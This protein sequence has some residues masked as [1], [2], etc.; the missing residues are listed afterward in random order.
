MNGVKLVWLIMPILLAVSPRLDAQVDSLFADDQGLFLAEF[1][2]YV[3]QQNKELEPQV[4][5]F[6]DV[7]EG[8]M[9]EFSREMVMQTANKM[10]GQ[11][12]PAVPLYGYYIEAV[13]AYFNG[14]RGNEHFFSWDEVVKQ[15]VD[16]IQR[17]NLND[18]LGFLGFSKIFFST[19]R[20]RI[21]DLGTNW[22][23][24]DTAWTFR[25]V[26]DMPGLVFPETD[27]VAI[28]KQDSIRI[29]ATSGVFFPLQL[30]WK[31][32]GGIVGWN[33][34]EGM[35]DVYCEF[36]EYEID[37]SKGFYQAKNAQLHYPLYFSDKLIPGTFEDKLVVANAATESS[38]PR[39]ESNEK[40]LNIDNFGKG[41]SFTGGFRM[42]GTTI[43]GTG[44][45]ENRAR[46]LLL[47]EKNEEV[48]LRAEAEL[49]TIRQEELIFGEDVSASLY[50]EKSDS[51][52]HPSIIM[53]YEIPKELLQLTRGKDGNDRYP[54]S[55]TYH[56]INIEAEKIMAYLEKDSL[57]IGASR[58]QRS[59]AKNYAAFE[60]LQFFDAGDYHRA[61]NITSVNPI[62]VLR[63][64][65]QEDETRRFNADYVASKINPNYTLK[66]IQ[67]LLY[68]LVANGFIAYDAQEQMIEVRDKAFLYA[69]AAQGKVDYDQIQIKSESDS[70]NAVMNLRNEAL[71]ING[72]P[73]LEFSRLQRVAVVPEDNKITVTEN[74]NKEFNGLLYA[75]YS[76]FQGKR[77]HFEYEDFKIRLD[78]IDFFDLYLPV[79]QA[80]TRG[81]AEEMPPPEIVSLS[82][83]IENLS[84]VLLIDAPM[85]KS[86]KNNIL[87][88]PSFQSDGNAF[89]YY[90]AD[91]SYARDSFF[92]QLDPFS[93]NNLDNFDPNELSFD[94][95]M[96]SGG[97]F[98]EFRQ[99]ITFQDNDRSLGFNH[100]SPV[101]GFPV[102]G[103]RAT[104]TGRVGLN[105]QGMTGQGNL[106]YQNASIDAEDFVFQP[107]RM[108]VS[109]ETFDLDEVRTDEKEIPELHGAS[110][111][112]DWKPYRD[113]MYVSSREGRAFDLYKDYEVSF[114]GT[115][116]L[117]P[118][119]LSGIG[120]IEWDK[121]KLESNL[122]SLGA[123]SARADTTNIGIKAP[124][125]EDGTNAV[126]TE[127]VMGNVDFEEQ[128]ARFESHDGNLETNL[129]YN[130]YK[131]SMNEFTWE[132]IRER[133]VFKADSGKLGVFTAVNPKQDSLSFEAK[134]ATYELRSNDLTLGGVPFIQ[135]CDAQV[136]PDSNKIHILPGGVIPRLFNAKIIA[137]TSNKYHVINRAAVEI[138]GRKSYLAS[139]YYEYNI[140]NR[141]QEILFEKIVGE[142]LQ[143][144]EGESYTET[145][146]TGKVLET[147]SLYIDFK[148]Q[149]QGEISLNARS[150]NLK[151]E[152]FARLDADRL[153]GREWFSVSSEG[154]K[155]DLA[156]QFDRPRNPDGAGLQTGFFI[157]RET[158]R[159]YPRVLMPLGFS[160]DRD[161][162]TVKGLVKYDLKRDA[163]TFGD[164][165][166]VLGYGLLGNR[167]TFSNRTGKV[168]GEGELNIG[169]GLKYVSMKTA[170]EIETVF[171]P[172]DSLG[173]PYAD[174]KIKARVMAGIKLILPEKLLRVMSN[175]LEAGSYNAPVISYLSDINYYKKAASAVFPIEN[176][177]VQEAI[178]GITSGF[179]ELP[180]RSNDYTF[181]FSDVPFTWDPNL[182]SFISTEKELGI[183]SIN[184][185]PLH[186]RLECY[187]EVKMPTNLKDRL[188][189]YIKSPSSLYYFFGFKDG[190]LNV[191]SNNTTFM[192]ELL[193]LKKNETV[194]K[195]DDGETYEILIVEPRTARLFMN[196]I[197]SALEE[198]K[199]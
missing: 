144:G 78:S 105:G 115:A 35:D 56:G 171:P 91:S 96:M 77:F 93:F 49:F 76:T 74:R 90:D 109:A 102:Y 13:N 107:K 194:I 36:V 50:L 14:E 179:L 159:L 72:I 28:R 63:R 70:A 1:R 60:S 40:I 151:F 88:F 44:T 198:Q 155:K 156:I 132:M 134:T 104:Y 82:S 94:G 116:V 23:G 69:D 41:I 27:L 33:R 47:N 126:Y 188:Y 120:T 52:H 146:A 89:V 165:L 158:A 121:A 192:D 45:E 20:L 71:T 167:L 16:R 136:I 26:E 153:P 182:Q 143:R 150:K 168:D 29:D 173:G 98:P 7:F 125:S 100:Q 112:I 123:A 129:P 176:E 4:L 124:G 11:R 197:N 118:G 65:S 164:S 131:T 79:Q 46:L 34:F 185:E 122:F 133:V 196:R 85:N 43:Y 95:K 110:V 128:M 53:R 183:I 187:M 138:L 108:T 174:Y 191:T 190:I 137:D 42:Q 67:G 80:K 161:I 172:V 38:Y 2:D 119:G 175:E 25:I 139:G 61:Q 127:G 73:H 55:S 193:A 189:I 162:M 199:K 9:D 163:F 113:S 83:R 17:R 86:G 154:D 8:Q 62:A 99:T 186:R 24:L 18:L 75:G 31:G 101:E 111:N 37:M 48:V 10:K 169:S 180:P 140:G 170:G 32:K 6:I 59:N 103:G 87:M 141:E 64:I 30:R 81:S 184:G 135:T 57:I 54:F 181:L 142:E 15:M 149:F 148:T 22:I 145:R 157:S 5:T 19:G 51:L 147:D 12:L 152:G 39:F 195:M 21:S 160:K 106:S 3:L 130:E 117:S 68:E 178:N 177:D 58:I 92:F 114:D 84:G 66:N 166:K 97:I